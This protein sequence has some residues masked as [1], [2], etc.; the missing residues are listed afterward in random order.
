MGQNEW[1]T[2][3]PGSRIGATVPCG[4]V[5]LRVRSSYSYSCKI[6]HRRPRAHSSANPPNLVLYF[7][8]ER[9]ENPS[10]VYY[11]P[12]FSPLYF[13]PNLSTNRYVFRRHE[14]P[15]IAGRD[16]VDLAVFEKDSA[17]YTFALLK[18]TTDQ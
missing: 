11:S 5:Q 17:A 8:G 14:H 6:I 15:W 18:S 7:P 16:R 13:V 9:A 3:V 1:Y 2:I 10:I 4:I 12:P